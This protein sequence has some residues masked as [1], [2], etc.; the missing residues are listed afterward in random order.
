MND[1]KNSSPTSFSQMTFAANAVIFD[2]GDKG[3]AAYLIRDGQ[4]EIRKGTHTSE[5]QKLAI[6]KKGDVL[7]ELALFDG[8]PRMAGAVALTKVKA[9]RI[10]RK[11]FLDRLATMDPSMK[12]IVL[13]MVSRVRK[14]ADEFMRRKSEIEWAKLKKSS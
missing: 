7:G 13:T 6:L 1:Q 11:E 5:P 4:V 3:D 14:M 9:I 10:S 8:R 12:G 2:E